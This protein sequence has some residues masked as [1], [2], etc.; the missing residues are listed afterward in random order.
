MP[1]KTEKPKP[2]RT[3]YKLTGTAS[4][5]YLAK[6]A[7]DEAMYPEDKYKLD[8]QVSEADFEN[9]DFSADVLTLA[10][11]WF[12]DDDI[13][14]S[15]TCP[16]IKFL[17][18][19]LE[20]DDKYYDFKKDMVRVRAKSTARQ[21]PIIYDDDKTLLTDTE[22]IEK[23][24]NGCKV[25][26]FVVPY[27]YGDQKSW[28]TWEAKLAKAEAEKDDKKRNKL[29]K[30]IMA[31]KPIFGVALGLQAVQFLSGT[32]GRAGIQNLAASMLDDTE[33]SVD[34]VDLDNDSDEPDE[35]VEL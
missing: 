13:E 6:T 29:I 17:N 30:K 35:S 20:E 5:P 24:T 2:K 34:D 3:L 8:V 23:I 18:E 19:D 27:C 21:K 9:N 7:K 12:D 15:D 31:D 11:S 26:M 22:D 32:S 28:K 16:S 1:T 10:Q 25:N 33:V 14:L 4:F